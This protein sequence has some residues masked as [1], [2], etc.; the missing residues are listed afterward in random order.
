MKRVVAY[1]LAFLVAAMP[2]FISAEKNGLFVYG[3]GNLKIESTGSAF[4][5][6]GD[7]GKT[8]TFTV[9]NTGNQP[10]SYNKAGLTIMAQGVTVKPWGGASV[11]L[12]AGKSATLTFTVDVSDSA[13][14]GEADMNVFLYNGSDNVGARSFT[15][16]LSI[17][18]KEAAPK[19][20]Y[21]GTYTVS[22][23]MKLSTNHEGGL[24]AGDDNLVTLEIFNR[25]NT[26]VKNTE[27]SLELPEGITFQQ[28]A[29]SVNAGYITIGDKYTARFHLNVDSKMETK[30]YPIKAVIGGADMSNN[31]KEVT[32]TY[33]IPVTAG[34]GTTSLEDV[35]ISNISIPKQAPAGEDFQ[36]SF[37]VVNTGSKTVSDLTVTVEVPEGVINK[38]RNVFSL[39]KLDKNSSKTQVVT[40][41]TP[42]DAEEKY[43]SLKI[44]VASGTGE[45]AASVQQ[46]AGTLVKKVG[47][48]TKTPQLMISDYNFGGSYVQAGDEFPLRLSLFNTNK[49]V[50]M[51]NIKVTVSSEDGSFVPVHG[52]NSFFVE[53]IGSKQTVE[54]M[55]MMTTKHDVEQKTIALSVDMTYEDESANEFTAKETISIPVIQETRL[56]V[57][58]VVAPPELYAGMQTGSSVKFYNMG[59]NTL[60]NLRADVSGDFDT[61]E[62][63][64]YYVGN[65]ESGKSD[66]FDFS[67]IPRQEGPMR[68]TVVFTY[69]DAS[70]KEWTYEKEFEFSVMA[71]MSMDDEFMDPDMIPQEKKTPWKEISIGAALFAAAVGVVWRKKHLKKKLDR[72]M[73]IDE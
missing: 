39:K 43:H 6:Q 62:S 32:R 52:S 42:T 58:D 38:T 21:S 51:Q 37:D 9:T 20:D 25:G 41:S 61:P 60:N 8:L 26:Y 40:L 31:S 28:G 53:D 11:Q 4:V 45:N 13:W 70:G 71:E 1:F 27:I 22:F 2:T 29:S 73:E 3:A 19:T 46:Y 7:S 69:E 15:A 30:S 47:G 54:K 48:K 5:V 50:H 44:T 12:E 49:T 34:G 72:E 36:L 56:M 14:T 65:M 10:I 66:S 59:K 17:Y 64:L 68:G 23:D 63:N 33:Y 67:F 16:G 35:D 18:E 55:L 24:I 57:D